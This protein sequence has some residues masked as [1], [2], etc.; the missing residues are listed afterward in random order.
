MP[1]HES[2]PWWRAWLHR[3]RRRTDEAVMWTALRARGAIRHPDDEEAAVLMALQGW[4]VFVQLPGQEHWRCACS[5]D[6]RRRPP[7]SEGG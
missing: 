6:D 3:R 2:C 7:T 1:D 5:D 4:A